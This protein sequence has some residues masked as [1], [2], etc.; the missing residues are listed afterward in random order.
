MISARESLR[1]AGDAARRRGLATLELAICLPLL[2]AIF[3][4]TLD[5]CQVIFLQQA[6]DTACYEGQLLAAEVAVTTD[7]VSTSCQQFL[8]EQGIDAAQVTTSPAELAAALPGQQITVTIELNCQEQ[9]F[10]GPFHR[11]NRLR[12]EFVGRR[13]PSWDAV[14][15]LMDDLPLEIT[16]NAPDLDD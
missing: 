1:C 8:Q 2:V 4:G 6:L 12:S 3:L 11:G 5:T 13:S 10:Y 14:P 16:L 15:G 7:E 9:S